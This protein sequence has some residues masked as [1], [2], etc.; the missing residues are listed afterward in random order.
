[1]TPQQVFESVHDFSKKARL[2]LSEYKVT[3]YNLESERKDKAVVSLIH[4]KSA[5]KY[6]KH[7]ETI[8]KEVI[9]VLLEAVVKCSLLLTTDDEKQQFIKVNEAIDL[10]TELSKFSHTTVINQSKDV[11]TSSKPITKP[12]AG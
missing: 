5:F 11:M 12:T 8:P 1:M 3:D 10:V 6:L 9:D 4:I 2:A 7:L